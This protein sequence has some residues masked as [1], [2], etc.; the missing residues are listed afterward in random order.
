MRNLASNFRRMDHLGTASEDWRSLNISTE[1][2]CFPSWIAD[3]VKSSSVRELLNECGIQN[4]GVYIANRWMNELCSQRP[5][6]IP[7]NLAF[8]SVPK[9]AAEGRVQSFNSLFGLVHRS[10]FMRLGSH[11]LHSFMGLKYRWNYS[12]LVIGRGFRNFYLNGF[13]YSWCRVYNFPC[14][15]PGVPIV[16]RSYWMSKGKRNMNK[17]MLTLICAC[18]SEQLLPGPYL[19][20]DKWR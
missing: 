19:K 17:R 7:K 1:E 9:V 2:M 5:D 8:G 18:I 14:Q 15:Y 20:W 16:N 6:I 12:T 11:F 10:S 4:I 13:L 3:T